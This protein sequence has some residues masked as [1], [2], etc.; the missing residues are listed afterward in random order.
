[1]PEP[2]NFVTIERTE[3]YGG[4][5]PGASPECTGAWE[6]AWTC[7]GSEYVNGRDGHAGYKAVRDAM[8]AVDPSIWVRTHCLC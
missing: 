3:V 2:T 8:L 4:N 1:M 6:T 5:N 7:D